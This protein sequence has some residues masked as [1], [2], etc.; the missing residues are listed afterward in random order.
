[1]KHFVSL[2]ETKCFKQGNEV[3][4]TEKRIVSSLE[5]ILETNRYWWR[6]SEV[7]ALHP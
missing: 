2:L 7:V 5:T 4:R 6:D 3:F 1:L